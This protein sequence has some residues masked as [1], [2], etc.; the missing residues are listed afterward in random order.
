MT[1]SSLIAAD[2]LINILLKG[3]AV[4]LVWDWLVA[5]FVPT[6]PRLPLVTI[7]GLLLLRRLV[8]PLPML[9][10]SAAGEHVVKLALQE[11]F[12]VLFVVTAALLFA[13]LVVRLGG[14][15]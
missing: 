5:P 11:T 7:L 3:L 2:F 4:F 9:E 8:L 6:L 10:V 13:L 1:M 14:G 15:S 12:N